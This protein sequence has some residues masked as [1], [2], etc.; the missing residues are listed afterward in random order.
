MFL[1]LAAFMLR[2][3]IVAFYVALLCCGVVHL[4]QDD[5]PVHTHVMPISSHVHPTPG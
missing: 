3:V 5:V 1:D 4:M 2:I